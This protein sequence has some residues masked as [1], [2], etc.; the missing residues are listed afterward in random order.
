[1]T[2]DFIEA[3]SQSPARQGMHA[4]GPSR[5]T[6]P[7]IFIITKRATMHHHHHWDL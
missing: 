5:Q 7:Q 1:M 3:A 2:N 6:S 4:V